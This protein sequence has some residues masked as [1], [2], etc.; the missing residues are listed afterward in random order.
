MAVR[1]VAVGV[2]CVGAATVA[3]CGFL[4]PD[5]TAAVGAAGVGVGG[6]VVGAVV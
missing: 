1:T 3:G 5:V 6:A 2:A 4:E